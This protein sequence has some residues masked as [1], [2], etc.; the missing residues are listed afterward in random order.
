MTGAV[1]SPEPYQMVTVRVSLLKTQGLAAAYEA[2]RL[3][4]STIGNIVIR[5]DVS[6]GI[7]PID[8]SNCSIENVG[9]L[10]FAGSD[11]AYPITLTGYEIINSSM[12]P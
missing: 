5:P 12:W 7:G 6:A 1:T 11:A 8:L 9:E 3:S 10:T 4:Q 2:Q